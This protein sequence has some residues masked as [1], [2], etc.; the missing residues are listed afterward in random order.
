MFDGEQRLLLFNRR[1][2]EMYGLNPGQLW[3]GMTLRDVVDL[4]YAAG[5]GTNM[6]PEQY[7]AWRDHIGREE[8]VTDTEVTLRDGRNAAHSS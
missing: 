3:I 5:T 1:F 6:L 7:A 4:R 8:R 2:A